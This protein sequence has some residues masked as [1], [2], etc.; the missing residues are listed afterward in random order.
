MMRMLAALAT[1]T[2]AAPGGASQVAPASAPR[3][4]PAPAPGVTPA[5][6]TF[7][8][9]GQVIQGGLIVASA[10]RDAVSVTLDG[11]ALPLA[12]D[13]RFLVGFD[14]DAGPQAVLQATLADVFQQLGHVL[15]HVGLA[16]LEAQA[17][18]EGDDQLI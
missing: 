10:P 14:R 1:L 11:T 13:G 18:V 6:A 17:L 12:P 9:T 5:A 4:A 8:W 2:L 7:R 16:H 15:L 3:P